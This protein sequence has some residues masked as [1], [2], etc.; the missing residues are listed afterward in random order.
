MTT[1]ESV[2]ALELRDIRIELRSGLP[3]VEGVSLTIR[4]GEIVGLVGESG[5]GKTTTALSIFGSTGNGLRLAGGEVVLAG[6]PLRDEAAF[7][8]ARGRLVSYV[9]QDPG[10]ALNPSLRIGSA[11]DDVVSA[12]AADRSRRAHLLDCV[13]LPSDRLFVLR[14]P[15]QLSGGQQQRVCIA[16][17]IASDPSLVVLDEPTTGL[18]VVTQARILRE[19]ERLRDREHVAMLYITHNMA[20]AAQIADTIAVMYAGELV[21]CG[22]APTVL[23]TPRHPYTRGLMASTPDHVRRHTLEVMQGIAVG[24]GKRPKGCSFAPR[25]PQVRESCVTEHPALLETSPGHAVRCPEWRRTPPM[26]W[27]TLRIDASLDGAAD[28][29]R[30]VALEVRNLRAEHPGRRGNS[31]VVRDI[32]FTLERSTCLALVGESGSGK[33]TIARVIAGL[34]PIAAGEVL[35]GGEALASQAAKRTVRQRREI[36]I[37]F[38]NPAEA[39]NPRSSVGAA[40][41]RPA[42]LLRGLTRSEA[43]AEVSRLLEAVRLPAAFASRYP[44]EL[45]GG[46]C[47]R[48][49]IARALAA[50]PSVMVCDEITAALDVSVQAVVLDL[51]RDL[52]R[53]TGLS[54]I[55]ITHDLGVV[56]SVADKVLVLEQGT[57]CEKGETCRVLTDPQHPYTRSL[58]AAAPSLSDSIAEWGRVAADLPLSSDVLVQGPL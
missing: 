13:G 54:M 33:T 9:P 40:I 53:G 28:R 27:A 1:T 31:A 56:A 20:V 21:E 45:S 43:R 15:H 11:I 30:P 42:Q 47:Q 19:L 2:P 39:L 4:Q 12:G 7:R 29:S 23:R 51:L 58:L 38:Q 18:D 41:A 6:K 14:Y 8:R 10:A 52:R 55:F 26:E 49:A 32:S 57:I 50:N 24:V 5:S 46:E 25:C 22:P 37:I 3:V 36:Q 48:V 17:A 35:L 34:H 44:R 16:G